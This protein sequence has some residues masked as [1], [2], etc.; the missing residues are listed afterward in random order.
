MLSDVARFGTRAH[1]TRLPTNGRGRRSH[2]LRGGATLPLASWSASA[3]SQ[4][5]TVVCVRST[6]FDGCHVARPPQ[7]GLLSAPRTRNFSACRFTAAVAPR[8]GSRPHTSAVVFFTPSAQTTRPSCRCS[9]LPPHAPPP[10]CSSHTLRTSKRV[11]KRYTRSAASIERR[12]GS[13]CVL[14]AV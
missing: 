9:Q 4:Q 10:F 3:S 1:L 14:L 5:S 7:R 6:S 2:Q 12:L 11:E 8:P 13:R